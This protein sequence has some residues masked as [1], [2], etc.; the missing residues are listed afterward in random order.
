MHKRLFI[1][2]DI[3]EEHKAAIG[4]L[5]K[6]LKQDAEQL[7]VKD[8]D[9][10]WVKP[11]QIHLTLKFLGDIEEDRIA[12]VCDAVRRAAAENSR[13]DGNVGFSLGAAVKF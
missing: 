6:Q 4:Q 2:I 5:Q 8:G 1:A 13:F 7:K 10:K 9:V 11:E 3:D 12:D